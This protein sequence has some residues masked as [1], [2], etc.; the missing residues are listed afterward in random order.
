[1]AL[2]VTTSMNTSDGMDADSS[3]TG[4]LETDF[5]YV[6][7]GCI[8]IDTDIE[9]HDLFN[10]SQTSVD[11][12]ASAISI[13]MLCMTQPNLDTKLNGGM[14]ILVK[15]SS[16]NIS[17]WNVGGKDTYSGGWEVMVA[18][19]SVTPDSNNGT[20]ATLTDIVAIGTGWKCLA[21]SKLS[22]NCFMDRS[23]YGTGEILKITGTNTTTDLGWS[24]VLSVG[25]AADATRGYLK[26]QTGSYIPKGP[27]KVGDDTGVLATTFTDDFNILI[28][29][30]SPVSTTYYGIT[31]VGNATGATSITLKS[32]VLKS[33]GARFYFDMSAANLNTFSVTGTTFANAGLVD[34]KAG[35]TATGN[36]FNDCGQIDPS[37]ATFETNTVANYVGAEGGALLWP[38]GTTVKNCT[39]DNNL[40]S[41]EILQTANQTYD[42]LVFI[43]EDNTTKQSTHLNNGGSSIN[44]SKNNGSNPLYYTAT[45]GGVVSFVGA[46]VTVSVNSV[47]TA[48]TD[49]SD[50]RVFLRTG[51][52]GSLPF[53]ASVTISNST[54]TAT[55]THT[56]H[57]LSTGDKVVNYS[58]THNEN[59]GVKTITVTGVSTYTYTTT[60]LTSTDTASTYFVYVEGLTDVNGDI[61]V[62]RVYPADQVSTGT[63]RK[64]TSSPFFKASPINT[65]VS[66][67]VNTPITAV[68]ISDD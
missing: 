3:L 5:A 29:G 25:D 23:T 65:T 47:T 41:I 34:F 18:H 19:T 43:N 31:G 22:Q 2:A 6:S 57:G 61:Q 20:V 16:G 33:A 9:T 45:G 62:S 59:L 11:M 51:A 68:M 46:S 27:I 58:T 24:E 28:F 44:I 53:N 56:S 37:T 14:R 60:S 36:V 64:S 38:A 52:A 42:N 32:Q 50:V 39:F 48:G 26:A 8:G 12:S 55:V 17:R 30:D 40:K 1:M 10:G 49:V 54:T 35:Q 13:A 66:G 7:T 4:V 67:T 15:D 63:A 21:K